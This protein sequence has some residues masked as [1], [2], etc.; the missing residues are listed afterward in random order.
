VPP[1]PPTNQ[2][3]LCRETIPHQRNQHGLA[4]KRRPVCTRDY[5]GSAFEDSKIRNPTNHLHFP[6]QCGGVWLPVFAP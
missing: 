5:E 1:T 2:S 4:T 6:L 3:I